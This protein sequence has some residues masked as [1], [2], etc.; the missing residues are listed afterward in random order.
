MLI[1]FNKRVCID[2]NGLFGCVC[3]SV[4][5]CAYFNIKVNKISQTQKATSRIPYEL[6]SSWMLRNRN[7]WTWLLRNK[8]I[9][10]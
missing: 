5:V 9:K 8:S 1:L 3:V 10:N 2:A 6:C 4:C 7:T